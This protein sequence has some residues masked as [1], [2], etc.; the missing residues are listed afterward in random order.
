MGLLSRLLSGGKNMPKPYIDAGWALIRKL[1]VSLNLIGWNNGIPSYTPAE[2]EAINRKMDNFQKG[3]ISPGKTASEEA[4]ILA[5]SKADP[6]IFSDIQRT[7]GSEAL[8]DLADDS[9]YQF[10]DEI[11]PDWRER[12]NT[13]LKAWVAHPQPRALL[14]LGHLLVKVGYRSEA[15][16]TFR[17][18]LLFPTYA[19]TFFRGRQRNHKP[20]VVDMIVS[21][22]KESMKDLE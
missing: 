17:V 10:S 21:E 4:Y 1:T 5:L 19:D 16:E 6:E 15:K 9:A 7:F 12:V 14:N 8:L 20:D 22:A 18:V 2:V 13:Y 3:A 11:P